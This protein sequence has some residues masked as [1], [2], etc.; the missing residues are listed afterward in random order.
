[1]DTN[2]LEKEA[3]D[4][5]DSRMALSHFADSFP[6]AEGRASHAVEHIAVLQALF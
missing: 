4:E 1:M 5:A 2:H 6:K 3:R